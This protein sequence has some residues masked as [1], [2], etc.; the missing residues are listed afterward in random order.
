LDIPQNVTIIRDTSLLTPFDE[1]QQQ[2]TL[3]IDIVT[4]IEISAA[5]AKLAFTTLSLLIASLA[6]PVADRGAAVS[7]S[8]E[9]WANGIIADPEGTHLSPDKAS[10]LAT[11]QTPTGK[12]GTPEYQLIK[13]KPLTR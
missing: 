8:L 1:G 5:M 2:I 3:H 13:A 7:F 11:N 6:G 4:Q 10:K 12:S 9:S